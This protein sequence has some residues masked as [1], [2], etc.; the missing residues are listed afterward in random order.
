MDTLQHVGKHQDT[1]SHIRTWS[2]HVVMVI[3]T[4]I[5]LT[6]I[7]LNDDDSVQVMLSYLY[8]GKDLCEY[9][10]SQM[11]ESVRLVKLWYFA[12]K[13]LQLR[14][15]FAKVREQFAKIRLHVTSR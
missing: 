12:K 4:V 5:R 6:G 9:V 15:V 14:E 1:D 3:A 8:L 2:A 11:N 13:F 7:K 10:V